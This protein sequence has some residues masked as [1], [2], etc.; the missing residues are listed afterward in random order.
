MADE[1]KFEGP[2]DAL[3][4]KIKKDDISLGTKLV[5]TDSQEA[6]FYS[7]SE[8]LDVFTAGTHTLTADNMPMLVKFF[9]ILTGRNRIFGSEIYFV[10][11]TI[12]NKL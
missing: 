1:I 7:G 3:V 2:S 12:K 6:I 8:S 9:K 10:N 11:K 4:W 5:V